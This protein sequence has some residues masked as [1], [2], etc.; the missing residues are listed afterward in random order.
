MN[1]VGGHSKWR[2]PSCENRQGKPVSSSKHR[3]HT[4]ECVPPSPRNPT[5]RI[6]TTRDLARPKSAHHGTGRDSPGQ[7]HYTISSSG[8]GSVKYSSRTVRIDASGEN[9]IA[10]SGFF[11]LRRTSPTAETPE[12]V[13]KTYCERPVARRLVDLE[14]ESS[15]VESPPVGERCFQAFPPFLIYNDNHHTRKEKSGK[16]NPIE[17]RDSVRPEDEAIL[18]QRPMGRANALFNHENRAMLCKGSH[19]KKTTRRP[20]RDDSS[21]TSK[22]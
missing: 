15:Q 11:R 16:G 13:F 10:K 3:A 21:K 22:G 9:R 20:D 8:I 6:E 14:N 7:T 5:G 1:R 12:P 19:T 18:R 4:R 2:K 17:R